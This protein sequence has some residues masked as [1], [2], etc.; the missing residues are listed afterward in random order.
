[1]EIYLAS[2]AIF[3]LA[4]F[5]LSVGVVFRGKQI[6]GH[7]GGNPTPA[8]LQGSKVGCYKHGNGNRISACAH[9]DCES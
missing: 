9:C 1:M 6:K 7:C 3:A 2:I 5:G 8:P 4:M